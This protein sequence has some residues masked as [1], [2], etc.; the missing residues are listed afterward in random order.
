MAY[1]PD[2]E[3]CT[4]QRLGAR[5]VHWEGHI[6]QCTRRT[7]PPTPKAKTCDSCEGLAKKFAELQDRVRTM[8][9]TERARGQEEENYREVVERELAI[10]KA[11]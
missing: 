11:R 2:S 10:L 3:R 6:G 4:S 9:Y 8:E 7:T 1:P 5:C